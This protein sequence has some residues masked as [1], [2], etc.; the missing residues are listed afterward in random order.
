MSA[1]VTP[2]VMHVKTKSA[3]RELLL[4]QLCEVKLFVIELWAYFK[5]TKI[6]FLEVFN[7]FVR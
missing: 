7:P 2:I 6:F 4:K 1:T 3:N 5:S